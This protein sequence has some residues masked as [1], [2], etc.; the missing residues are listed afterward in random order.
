MYTRIKVFAIIMLVIC[1]SFLSRGQLYR[2]ALGLRLGYTNGIT[3]K[4]FIK[5]KAAFEGIANFYNRGFGVTGLY[6]I[7]GRAFQSSQFNWLIG[8]GGHIYGWNGYRKKYAENNRSYVVGLDG[9]IGLEAK[10][11]TIPLAV[12]IDW[13]P[14]I[15]LIN[16]YGYGADELA[17]SLRYTW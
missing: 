4:T 16:Y 14:T 11:K 10:F 5:P 13:K 3:Y 6:E 15:D 2:S 7:H 17:L 1:G 9:I 12:S 8:G